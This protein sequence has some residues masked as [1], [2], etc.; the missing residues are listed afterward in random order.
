MVLLFYNVQVM[1]ESS[2]RF[3][4]I[5]SKK[6]IIIFL[7]DSLFCDNVCPYKTDEKEEVH[8]KYASQ[9]AAGGEIAA[10]GSGWNGLS[11]ATRTGSG[12][13]DGEDTSLTNQIYAGIS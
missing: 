8:A 4:C 11:R 6:L 3:V 7:T 9:R 2:A 13:E 1:K 10:G 5:L 12:R